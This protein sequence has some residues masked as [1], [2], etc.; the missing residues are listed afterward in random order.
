MNNIS[1]REKIGEKCKNEQ[2][3]RQGKR[4]RGSGKNARG[5]SEWHVR[6]KNGEREHRRG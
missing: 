6:K 5:E 2:I 4:G 1:W 3:K